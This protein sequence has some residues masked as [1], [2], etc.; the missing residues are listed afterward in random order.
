[1]YYELVVPGGQTFQLQPEMTDLKKNA[2][3]SEDF[4]TMR[5]EASFPESEQRPLPKESRSQLRCFTTKAFLK[6][7]AMTGR[8]LETTFFHWLSWSNLL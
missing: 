1:M 8:K 2:T 7:L 4:N 5:S 6:P 3:V